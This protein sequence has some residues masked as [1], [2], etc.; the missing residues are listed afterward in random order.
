LDIRK[1]FFT[2]CDE[3]LE[4]VT[5]RDDRCPSLEMLK[6]RL[7]RPLSNLIEL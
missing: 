3:V 2:K 1:K 6:V 7:D 5:Q 4:L